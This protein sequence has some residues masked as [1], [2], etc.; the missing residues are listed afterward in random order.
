MSGS[1][2][3]PATTVV[4]NGDAGAAMRLFDRPLSPADLDAGAE[5]A[6]RP[7]EAHGSARVGLLLFRIGEETF[8]LP[9][10][11]LRRVAPVVRCIP[12][13]HR[14]SGVL[15]GLCNI[16]GQLSLCTDLARLLGLPERSASDNTSADAAAHRRMVL[17]GPP[18]APWAFEVDAIV[19]VER[20]EQAA[21]RPP[22]ITVRY[23]LADFTTGIADV[24]GETVTVLDGERI[25]KGF[26]GG[27]A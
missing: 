5:W 20:V 6:A 24:R 8:G 22:P 12:I 26:Q 1:N 11:L 3:N 18:D 17:I 25:L 14:S 10:R 23:A 15:R 13:P 7:V 9:A 19:G 4:S 21:I 2:P 16:R 27:I